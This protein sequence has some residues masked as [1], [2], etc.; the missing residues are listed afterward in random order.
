MDMI[1]FPNTIEQQY[2]EDPFIGRRATRR[3]LM[4]R[5]K[6]RPRRRIKPIRI[7]RP[8][9]R[10]INKQTKPHFSGPLIPS[11]KLIPPF[12]K[13]IKKPRR[14]PPIKMGTLSPGKKKKPI[15]IRYIKGGPRPRPLTIK[16]PRVAMVSKS[17]Q[18]KVER[19]RRQLFIPTATLLD[20]KEKH[21][22]MNKKEP[23]EL[24]KNEKNA[25]PKYLKIGL[26]AVGGLALT[27]AIGYGLRKKLLNNGRT[28]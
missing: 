1:A 28:S 18:D 14:Y 15:R 27:A 19:Q 2:N 16:R 17:L 9:I 12:P 22:Q 25:N 6:M 7:R 10:P 23:K 8:I 24:P 5:Y 13:P 11:D 4:G 21:Q 20:A 3:R 26:I